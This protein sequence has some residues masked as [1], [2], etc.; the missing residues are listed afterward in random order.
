MIY[1]QNPPMFSEIVAAFPQAAQPGAVFAWGD[2]I[3]YPAGGRL[4]P[5]LIAHE[6]VH[7]Q[8]HAAYGGPAAWWKRYIA[9]P[10][11]RL[12]QEIPAHRAEYD[13]YC[14]LNRD[15]GARARALHRI[16][17]RLASELYGR[18][19]TFTEARN[20]IQGRTHAYSS[21]AG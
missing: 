3:Y 20:A 11:F 5:E 9:D 13:A 17:M 16:A 14:R 12:D 19:I 1:H 21:H 7:A 10:A 6:A 18:L 15:R 4:P 8:Q 2:D